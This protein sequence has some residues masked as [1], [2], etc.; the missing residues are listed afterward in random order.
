MKDKLCLLI[1]YFPLWEN[2][3]DDISTKHI[4]AYVDKL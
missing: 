2:D 4:L 1:Y 3:D